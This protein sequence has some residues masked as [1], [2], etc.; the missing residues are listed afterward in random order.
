MVKAD[1]TDE[2]WST[3]RKHPFRNFKTLSVLSIVV[4]TDGKV[5]DICIR[6][7]IEIGVDAQAVKAV[8]QYRFKPATK[9]EITVAAHI[10]LEVSFIG[11]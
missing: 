3:S 5:H 10:N 4:G 6:E 7:P 2:Q 1:L 9:D 11:C 8:R